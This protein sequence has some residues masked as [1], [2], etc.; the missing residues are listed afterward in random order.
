MCTPQNELEAVEVMPYRY[1]LPIVGSLSS[2]SSQRMKLYLGMAPENYTNFL[3]GTLC[4]HAC[5]VFQAHHV[6][7][8]PKK[9]SFQVIIF[10]MKELARRFLGMMGATCFR[11]GQRCL[12][13]RLPL[14]RLKVCH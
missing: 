1:S 7:N 13:C 9:V 4:K 12:I 5:I 3:H 8:C 11:K 6:E 10:C 14:S 2:I